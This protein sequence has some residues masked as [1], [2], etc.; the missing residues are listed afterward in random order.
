ML[1][2]IVLWLA[3]AVATALA[4]KTASSLKEMLYHLAM[5]FAFFGLGLTIIPRIVKRINKSRFN[6]FAKH[7]PIAYAMAV[8]LAYCVLAGAQDPTTTARLD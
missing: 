6:V 3:L 1:E 4:T 7:S 5:T 8:L 2:D